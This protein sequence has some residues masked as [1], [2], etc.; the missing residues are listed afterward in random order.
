M[1]EGDGGDRWPGLAAG[2]RRRRKIRLGLILAA[3]LVVPLT[4]GALLLARPWVVQSVDSNRWIFSSPAIAVDSLGHAHMSYGRD[5]LRY[6]TNEGGSWVVATI[7]SPAYVS[8]TAIAVDRNDAVHI[9]YCAAALSGTLV[10]YPFEA[11]YAT[12]RGG[13]WTTTVDPNGCA[14]GIAVDSGGNV[15]MTYDSPD[16]PMEPWDAFLWT[17]KVATNEGGSWRTLAVVA[18]THDGAGTSIAVDDLGHIHVG[19]AD[20]TTLRYLTNGSGAWT[21]RSLFTWGYSTYAASLAVDS[22]GAVH[23]TS[24]GTTFSSSDVLVEYA[25]NK[26]GNWTVTPIEAWTYREGDFPRSALAI[27]PDDRVHVVYG[28]GN[29]NI[30]RHATKTPSGWSIETVDSGANAGGSTSVAVDR[31][32]GIHIAY[33]AGGSSHYEVRRASN[34]VDSSNTSTFLLVSIPYVLFAEVV[35]FATGSLI[36]R[37][38]NRKRASLGSRLGRSPPELPRER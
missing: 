6:A 22:D 29:R 34:S 36:S 12:N 11:R 26:G 14:D 21:N 35:V 9:A 3:V 25:T 8:H 30:L 5:G 31:I 17:V 13:S 33:D 23:L 15:Y 4:L 27:G 7:D 19:Y 20:G 18:T 2:L 32:G 16:N 1:D 38:R 10:V 28:G 24:V 37:N